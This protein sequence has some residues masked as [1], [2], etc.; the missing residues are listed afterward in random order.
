MKRHI[1]TLLAI[2]LTTTGFAFITVPPLTGRV[3]DYA[4][5]IS[6]EVQSQLENRLKRHEDSTSNQIVVLTLPSLEGE[7]LEEA[8]N[9]IFNTWKLGQRGKDNG[10]LL[11]VY[12]QDR[13]LRIEVG[14]GLEGVLTDAHCDRIIRNEI[15]PYFKSKAYGEGIMAGITAIQG[16][17]HGTYSAEDPSFWES[18]TQYEGI[19]FPDCLLAGSFVMGMLLVFTALAIFVEGL[20][21]WFLFCFL[22]FFYL[23]FPFVIFGSL[24]GFSILAA[25]I[26]IFIWSKIWFRTA[27]GKVWLQKRFGGS[28]RGS[29]SAGNA[30]YSSSRRSSWSSS[31]SSFSGGGGRSGGGGSSGSW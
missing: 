23:T 5:I 6:P 24:T 16:A 17:I 18:L 7:I 10:V 26:T 19:G 25:Y 21:S 11:L 3:N 8:A 13:T 20:L 4:N 27:E 12:V 28:N 29:G 30:S 15:T 1:L 14:Y 2:L 31:S 22:L 9:E